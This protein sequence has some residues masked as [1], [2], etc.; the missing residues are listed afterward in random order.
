V[1]IFLVRHA[2]AV[3][4]SGWTQADELRPLDAKGERQAGG[5][6]AILADVSLRRICSSPTLRCRQT[7]DR[8]ASDHSIRVEVDPRISGSLKG[9]VDSGAALQL[10]EEKSAAPILI[11]A[12]GSLIVELLGALGVAPD[13]SDS[14]RCQK[15]SVWV[16]ERKAGVIVRVEYIPPRETS[17]GARRAVLDVGSNSMSLLVADVGPAKGEIQPVL[18]SRAEL[19]LG[20]SSDQVGAADSDRIV[21]LGRT[22]RAEAEGVGSGEM[23]SVA[24]AS[25]RNAANGTQVADRLNQVLE[26]P[27]RILSGPEEAEIVYRAVQARL[28]L[29]GKLTVV[30]DLGGGSLDIALGRGEKILYR[31]SEPLGVTRLHAENVRGDPM[32]R[33]Q[34]NAIRHRVRSK[35][36]PHLKELTERQPFSCAVSGGTG[37]ALAKLVLAKRDRETKESVCGVSILRV[38]LE[39][40]AE[41]LRTATHEERI[42][43]PAMRA[44][45]ADLLPTGAI[46][47][48]QLL[49]SLDLPELLVSDWGLREGVLLGEPAARL[50]PS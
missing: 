50:L 29:N 27:L 40:L 46:I 13:A 23:V 33:S 47:L 17:L 39:A 45:R 32:K 2:R 18:R 25:L 1:K 9:Q 3:K 49:E 14:L 19:R 7:V 36:K 6:R 41:E 31:A 11:C 43:M 38:E 34:A 12:S 28:E 8:L 42:G 24:T 44:P 15:G 22:M 20:A 48:T 21:K 30:V 26:A 37:R 35:L 4:R 5:I 16:L 10:L